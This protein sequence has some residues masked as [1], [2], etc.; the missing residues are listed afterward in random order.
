MT[1][2]MTV[3][4]AVAADQLG[5]VLPH[6][7][8]LLDLCRVSRNADHILNDRDL[9]IVE[10]TAFREAGG[11]TIVELS[12]RG[13]S[14]DPAGLQEIA[15]ATGL[16][17]VMGA[18]WYREPYYDPSLVRVSI[19]A[20]TEQTIADLEEGVDESGIRAGIIGEIGCDLDYISPV[21]ERVHRAAARA[22]RRTGAAISTHA[23]RCPAGLDQLDLLAEEGVDPRRVVVGHCGTYPFP[24]YHRAIAERGAF[25]QFDWVG[26][27]HFAWDIQQN[28]DWVMRLVRA[29]FISQIL[30]SHDVCMKS[31]L[32]AY[33]G[34]GY[35]FVPARFPSYLMAAGL[36]AG[37]VRSI[38]VDNPRRALT[39]A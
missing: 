34:A 39:G 23:V 38:L 14:R 7:H 32:K 18:G 35:D 28:V 24:E 22:H 10:A 29:G 21:E 16:N 4:G 3:L 27:G 33:G 11:G 31:H 2:V 12:N 15:R 20:L 9:A 30:L 1:E 36:D 6:E 8:L 5:I 37:E 13:L 17:I 19:E 25:V 26:R